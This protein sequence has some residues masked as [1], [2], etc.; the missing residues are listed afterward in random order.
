MRVPDSAKGAVALALGWSSVVALIGITLTLTFGPM[1]GALGCPGGCPGGDS[2]LMRVVRLAAAITA[3]FAV[4][5]GVVLALMRAAART[6]LAGLGVVLVGAALLVPTATGVVN[7]VRGDDT[8]IWPLL[9]FLGLGVP[10]LVLV[11][12][13]VAIWRAPSRDLPGKG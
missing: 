9:P 5:A 2:V 7:V 10:G 6:H 13:G 12:A 4:F 11:Y 1:M 8:A 3:S